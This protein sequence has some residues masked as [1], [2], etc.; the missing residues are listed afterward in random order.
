A[1]GSLIGPA[2][3]L[4]VGPQQINAIVPSTIPAAPLYVSVT[5]NGVELTPRM[6]VLVTT[7]RFA[8]FSKS[9][10]GFGPASIQQYDASGQ[11]VFNKLTAAAK[12]GSTVTLLGT[13]L[14][15]LPGGAS[16]TGQLPTATMRTDV[17]VYISGVPVT[18]S[19]TG[20]APG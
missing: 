18:P 20:R 1:C 2:P 5:I 16:D 3:L 8:P 15:P 10:F 12:P 9:G 17:T 4:Y 7:G 14:G 6:P 11:L 19:Y 13:G